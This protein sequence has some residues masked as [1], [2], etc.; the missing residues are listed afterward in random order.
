MRKIIHIDMDCFFAAVEMREDPTLR[1]VPLA[2]G[3]ASD[4]R[5][6]IATC[7]Y[8]ARSYG[9]RSA[10]ATAHAL[11][12]CPQ[13]RLLP[14]RMALYQEVS[15]ELRAIFSRYAQRVEPL[16]L[17]EAYLDVTDSPLC[18]GSAT[19]IAEAIRRD[20]R[21][22]LG[23]TASAGVAPNKFL[24]K[25]ASD[26]NKPDGLFVLTPEQ[27]PQFVAQLPLQKIPGIGSKTA[28]RLATLGLHRGCD[29]LAFPPH[30]LLRQ[31]GKCGQMLL[32]RVRGLD[33]SPV[34]PTRLRKSV[35]VEM[36]LA[37]DLHQLDEMLP[38]LDQLEVDLRRRLGRHSPA[39]EIV[40]QGVKLKFADFQQTTVERSSTRLDHGLL[41]QLLGQAWSRGEGKGVR[42]LGLVVGLPCATPQLA[43]PTQLSLRF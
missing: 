17:D 24:A 19:L 16:S 8:P 22:E 29:V 41:Q 13:L 25:I 6:V 32:Q 28:E 31:F 43:A 20:I 27:V 14:G 1:E 36:T 18:R 12:L 21:R 42:L 38:V 23:L 34:E 3:G 37:Q 39:G 9:V 33:E 2:I 11:R 40:R 10:M 30:E 26:M 4:R 7:N 15:A 35:G 5:G